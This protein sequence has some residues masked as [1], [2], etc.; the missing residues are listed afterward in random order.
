MRFDTDQVGSL[1]LAQSKQYPLTIQDVQQKRGSEQPPQLYD[2]TSL[3]V[4]CNR[5]FGYSAET[6]LRNIQSL[7]EK[8]LTT[9]P[10]VD[11]KFLTDDIYAKCPGIIQ[12]LSVVVSLMPSQSLLAS[13]LRRALSPL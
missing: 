8:R 9:Y 5:K 13:R 10:R 3:Q 1:V 11:T 6:T 4:D 2:L 7:Y 12:N